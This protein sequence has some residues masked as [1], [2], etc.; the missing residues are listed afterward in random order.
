VFV[1]KG[2]DPGKTDRIVARIALLAGIIRS[3]SA[4]ISRIATAKKF[5]AN[6]TLVH[7]F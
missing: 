1:Q 6:L 4:R 5:D 2:D 7:L 3:V